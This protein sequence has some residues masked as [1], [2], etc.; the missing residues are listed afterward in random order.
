MSDKNKRGSYKKNQNKVLLRQ[1]AKA[2]ESSGFINSDIITDIANQFGVKPMKIRNIIYG[3]ST[4]E[5]IIAALEAAEKD[6]R[7]KI[8]SLDNDKKFFQLTHPTF[9]V[10]YFKTLEEICEKLNLEYQVV[11]NCIN[12]DNYFVPELPE[13]EQFGI[14]VR[15]FE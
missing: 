8:A 6:E 2:L 13:S 3:K 7:Q 11:N 9:K 12:K 5:K 1:R 15:H 10:Q 4:D 14:Y